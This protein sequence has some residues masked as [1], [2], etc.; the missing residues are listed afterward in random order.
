LANDRQTKDETK[1]LAG[2]DKFAL[3]HNRG[4]EGTI[5]VV[6]KKNPKKSKSRSNLKSHASRLIKNQIKHVKTNSVVGSQ[7][8]SSMLLLE[9]ALQN[10]NQS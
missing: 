3:N 10:E 2:A 5:P 1:D 6:A 4:G 9:N 7:G 8:P